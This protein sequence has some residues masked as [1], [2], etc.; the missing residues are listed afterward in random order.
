M[1]ILQQKAMDSS[2]CTVYSNAE[3]TEHIIKTC[4]NIQYTGCPPGIYKEL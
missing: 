3:I 2:K 4:K 1:K